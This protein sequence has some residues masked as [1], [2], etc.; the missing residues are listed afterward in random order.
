MAARSGKHEG[1]QDGPKILNSVPEHAGALAD[2]SSVEDVSEPSAPEETREEDHEKET[3]NDPSPAAETGGRSEPLLVRIAGAPRVIE[4][5]VAERIVPQVLDGTALETV[6]SHVG[7]ASHHPHG[8][9]PSLRRGQPASPAAVSELLAALHSLERDHQGASLL[10]RRLSYALYRLAL[11]SQVLLTEVWPG[12]FDENA[13]SAIRAVQDMVERI[14]SGTEE[15][16]YDPPPRE[17]PAL[18]STS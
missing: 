4:R 14:L 6:L 10:D 2:P 17:V 3:R 16:R 9:L 18:E 13:T 11:E 8:F 7:S 15:T 1:D 5:V 12:V